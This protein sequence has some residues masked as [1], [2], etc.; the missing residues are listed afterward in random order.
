MAFLTKSAAEPCN[1]VF[2]AILS[3][4]LLGWNLVELMS[5]IFLTLPSKV[6]TS[7]VSLAVFTTPSKNSLTFGKESKKAL[8]YGLDREQ[9]YRK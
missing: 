9:K 7:P 2:L 3:A 1:R 5:S 6:T 4:A 8:M